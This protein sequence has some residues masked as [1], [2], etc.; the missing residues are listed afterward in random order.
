MQI[1]IIASSPHIHIS[2][3][4]VYEGEHMTGTR[5]KREADDRA[6]Q[7]GEYIVHSG[8]TVRAA[9]KVFGISKS[10]VHTDVTV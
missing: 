9:A 7:L 10:T 6:M 3:R 5:E 2:T 8:A 1:H 4:N